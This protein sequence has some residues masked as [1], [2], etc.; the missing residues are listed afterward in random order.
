MPN[1]WRALDLLCA[2]KNAPTQLD[3]A[4]AFRPNIPSHS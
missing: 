1:A 2:Y 3:A 4:I